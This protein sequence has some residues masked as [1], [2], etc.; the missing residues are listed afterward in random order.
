[1]APLTYGGKK[2]NL[3]RAIEVAEGMKA[4]GYTQVANTLAQLYAQKGD[5]LQAEAVYGKD[6]MEGQF[7]GYA[8]AMAT[9]ASFWN[10]QKTNL[11]NAEKMV[12]AAIGLAPESAS[13]RQIAATLYL[14][15]GKTDKAV[16]TYG[17][18][19]IRNFK[20]D[21]YNLTNYARFWNQKKLNLE[22]AVEALEKAVENA[23]SAA[24]TTDRFAIQNAASLFYQ[25]G[26]PERALQIFGP[27]FIKNRMDDPSVLSSYAGFWASKK[28]NLESALAAAEAAVKLKETYA[29][30]MASNWDV[31]ATVYWT[32]GRLEDA[33]KAE[34]KAIEMDEG[35]NAEY[36]KSQL[37]KIQAEIDKKKKDDPDASPRLFRCL[38][39][40]ASG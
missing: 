29:M 31:L 12:L 14:D 26:K 39:G 1:V 25:L 8:S 20:V 3:D 18:A 13:Y 2:E 28:T 4:F 7:T 35:M 38:T 40:T 21:A 5:L 9:Y 19:F 6:F 36:Y 24:G 16:E 37:K 15:Q 22:S 11:E 33:L 27:E 34:E 32:L 17:P 23:A 30:N 10:Q